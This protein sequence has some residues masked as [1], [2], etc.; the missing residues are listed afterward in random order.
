[1]RHASGY[2]L[3]VAIVLIAAQACSQNAASHSRVAEA[4]A[5]AKPNVP[6]PDST[7]TARVLHNAD[8]GTSVSISGDNEN[9]SATSEQTQKSGGD[10]D[11]PGSYDNG[12][13]EK[14]EPSHDHQHASTSDGEKDVPRVER[15]DGDDESAPIIIQEKAESGEVAL[16][17]GREPTA[18]PLPEEKRIVAKPSDA[19][20]AALNNGRSPVATPGDEGTPI[21][22]NDPKLGKTTKKA[23]DRKR[24]SLGELPESIQALD[25]DSD[26]QI[27]LYEWPRKTIAQFKEIDENGDGFLTADELSAA[28]KKSKAAAEKAKSTEDKQEPKSSTAEEA[29][30]AD[31]SESEE[32]KES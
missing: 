12:R 10:S 32:E 28:A 23:D 5:T 29:T 9:T 1:M 15:A 8:A 24:K 21:K 14:A 4:D 16:N 18:T 22:E 3:L 17:N 26:G 11:E 7:T 2:L 25:K 27:G 6:A 19:E 20:A 31:D 30:K 13:P